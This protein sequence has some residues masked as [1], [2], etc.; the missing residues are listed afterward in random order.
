MQRGWD[1]AVRRAVRWGARLPQRK[2]KTPWQPP[3]PSL[4]SPL[5]SYVRAAARSR[6]G[7]SRTSLRPTPTPSTSSACAMRCARTPRSSSPSKDSRFPFD[8]N[9]LS[10]LKYEQWGKI[11]AST[12]SGGCDGEL[13]KKIDALIDKSETDSPVFLFLPQPPR[14]GGRRAP[15]PASGTAATPAGREKPRRLAWRASKQAKADVKD[16]SDWLVVVAVLNRL[17]KL[18]PN[19]PYIIQQLALATY[20]SEQPD[21]LQSL[22]KA[23]AILEAL[24]P[25]TSC[26]AETVGLWGA[27]HK[28]LWEA[29]NSPADLD[30]A[31]AP[32]PGDTSSRTTTTTGS[33]SPSC[34]TCAPQ[35]RRATRLPPI[36]SSPSA[37][38]IEVL[39]LC[40]EA[41]ATGHTE[42]SRC[43]LGQCD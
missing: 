37:S 33:T 24:S 36:A 41:L 43:V 39:T 34:S 14:R 29:G 13:K 2:E 35:G 12:R 18:Q 30:R 23:R 5:Y 4:I 8:L 6:P 38:G 9:H 15:A 22:Q 31:S 28:R 27:V 42:G 1:R 11:L 26:D 20:K 19:D 25:E 40:D 7:R 16:R 3:S 32:T 21:A 10:I 17:R